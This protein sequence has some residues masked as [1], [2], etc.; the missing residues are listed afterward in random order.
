MAQRWTR[1]DY[2]QF[3]TIH[4]HKSG[5]PDWM[6]LLLGPD[7][8]RKTLGLYLL[9]NANAPLGAEHDYASVRDAGHLVWY[10]TTRRSSY[11]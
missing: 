7:R 11:L 8:I 2:A 3:P 5:K 4:R 6:E 9:R 1:D 10:R